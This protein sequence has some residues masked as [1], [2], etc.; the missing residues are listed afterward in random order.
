MKVAAPVQN[1]LDVCSIIAI[2][3]SNE[4]GELLRKLHA[5]SCDLQYVPSWKSI[6]HGPLISMQ[7]KF[8]KE[9]TN[10]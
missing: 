10:H 5:W 4:R 9:T 1:L 6:Q 8:T 3:F 7:L 2:M